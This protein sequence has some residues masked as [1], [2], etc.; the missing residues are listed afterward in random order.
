MIRE[1]GQFKEVLKTFLCLMFSNTHLSFFRF[2]KKV[3]G[4]LSSD[5]FLFFQT[6]FDFLTS[7]F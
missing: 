6:N 7:R 2:L 1:I 4:Y 5:C 3:T